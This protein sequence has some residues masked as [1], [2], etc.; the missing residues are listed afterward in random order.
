MEGKKSVCV[1]VLGGRVV[2]YVHMC[3]GAGHRD[4]RKE[5]RSTEEFYDKNTIFKNTKTVSHHGA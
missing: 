3:M 4:R 2:G 1:C 5:E